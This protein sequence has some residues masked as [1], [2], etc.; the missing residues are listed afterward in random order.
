MQE[1]GDAM[2]KT[3]GS[4]PAAVS[5][6]ATRAGEIHE[7]SLP[8][9]EWSWVEP[10]IWTERMLAA[11]AQGVKGGKWYSLIDNIRW[12]NAFFAEHGLFSLHHAHVSSSAS[13]LAGDTIN[14]RAGCGRSARPV[15]REGVANPIA[16]PYP[17]QGTRQNFHPWI[18]ACAGMTDKVP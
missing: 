11:L 12:P 9:Q 15:R 16:A 1:D 2:T 18:P 13:P 17:Y 6:R 7:A 8:H 10:R 3:D 14:R 5:E 4:A